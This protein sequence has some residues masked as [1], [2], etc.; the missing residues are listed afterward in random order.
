M[1]EQKFREMISGYANFVRSARPMEGVVSNIRMPFQRSYKERE[2]A[3]Q[4][5][6]IEVA[7]TV[8]QK[9]KKVIEN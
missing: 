4:K 2:L 1:P 8:Y 6:T 7:D 3:K 5:N 9:L